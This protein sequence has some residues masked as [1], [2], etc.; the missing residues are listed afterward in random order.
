MWCHQII[1]PMESPSLRYSI[2]RIKKAMISLC[3]R[4]H[5]LWIKGHM[6]W[7]VK[8]Y[9]VCNCTEFLIDWIN[10]SIHSLCNIDFFVKIF[11]AALSNWHNWEIF[12][13]NVIIYRFLDVLFIPNENCSISS[14]VQRWKTII[15]SVKNWAFL[16]M[17]Y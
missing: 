11:N 15:S 10:L 3:E 1:G 13:W 8:V 17:T 5:F 16:N 6:I 14:I 4:F 12:I 9:S 2:N 7:L